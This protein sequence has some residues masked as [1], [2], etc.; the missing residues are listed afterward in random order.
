MK[1]NQ[2]FSPTPPETL[3]C[4]TAGAGFFG[5]AIRKLTRSSVNHAFLAYWSDALGGWMAGPQA[6]ERGVVCVSAESV[7]YKSIRC[8]RHIRLSLGKGLPAVRWTIGKKYDWSG[9]LG[10]LAVLLVRA[11]TRKRIKNPWQNPGRFFCSEDCTQVLCAAGVPWAQRDDASL[12]S[13]G[14]LLEQVEIDPEMEE[15]AAPWK[16]P[17]TFSFR[18]KLTPVV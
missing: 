3:L 17:G 11:V 14:R 13:P 16:N 1:S 2:R 15:V 7:E 6:D 18:A 9:I 4:L 10:F 5:W 12:T 8:F